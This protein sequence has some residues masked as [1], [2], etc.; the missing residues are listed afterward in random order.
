MGQRGYILRVWVRMRGWYS[1]SCPLIE[2]LYFGWIYSQNECCDYGVTYS[3]FF[4]CHMWFLRLIFFTNFS[5]E[6]WYLLFIDECRSF[7]MIIFNFGAEISSNLLLS[8]C[9]YVCICEN[10]I[11]TIF[12]V[13]ILSLYIKLLIFVCFHQLNCGFI[14]LI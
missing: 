13:P 12:Y 4:L 3:S 6:F 14:C 5:V 10:H 7:S 11:M 9:I 1:G 2:Q 8:F